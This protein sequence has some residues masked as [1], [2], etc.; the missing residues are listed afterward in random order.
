MKKIGDV[1]DKEDKVINIIKDEIIKLCVEYEKVIKNMS[2]GT[3][4]E[5]LQSRILK[6]KI[7]IFS[8]YLNG[9]KNLKKLSLL[10][11]SIEEDND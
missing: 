11:L 9:T 8:S 5:I 4:E 6:R 2:N 3:R 7:G 10:A 1:L